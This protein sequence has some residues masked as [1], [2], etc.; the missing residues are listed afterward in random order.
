LTVRRIGESIHRFSSRFFS[1]HGIISL[2]TVPRWHGPKSFQG[3]LFRV[4]AHT[5]AVARCSHCCIHRHDGTSRKQAMRWVQ[6]EGTPGAQSPVAA[7]AY[8]TFSFVRADLR[9]DV[10]HGTGRNHLAEGYG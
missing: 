6:A 1:L 4:Y 3:E 10:A 5:A 8:R 9:M 2:E 7:R